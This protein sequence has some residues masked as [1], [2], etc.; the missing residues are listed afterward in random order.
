MSTS[1]IKSLAD[2]Q[3]CAERVLELGSVA[4]HF[5]FFLDYYE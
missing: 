3:T 1:L 5:F 2:P 4:I